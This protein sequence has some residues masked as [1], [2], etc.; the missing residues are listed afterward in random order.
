MQNPTKSPRCRRATSADVP[1]IAELR[2][3]LKTD[4]SGTES[5]ERH[6]QFITDFIN[7]HDNACD[8]NF[9]H[10]VAEMSGQVV[11]VL[12]VVLVHKIASPDDM[13]ALWGYLTNVYALPDARN[14]GI[15]SQLLA[16]ATAWAKNEGLEMLVVWPSD[17]SYAFYKRAGFRRNRD[18]L[19]LDLKSPS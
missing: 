4:D 10:W 15:G 17:R 13:N 19:V 5:G 12:S 6:S 3:K 18:P 1:S 2:W 7:W 8:D 9:V 11:A 16:E 14:S